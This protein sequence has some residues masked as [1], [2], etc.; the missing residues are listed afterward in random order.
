VPPLAN[1][2]QQQGEPAPA[3]EAAAAPAR[4]AGI[5]RL[6]RRALALYVQLLTRHRFV[7]CLIGLIVLLML[8]GLTLSGASWLAPGDR[9]LAPL[10]EVE[11]NETRTLIV[12]QEEGVEAYLDGMTEF[13]AERMWD[14]YADVVR[15]D[16][17]ARGRSVAE[18][19]RGLDQARRNGAAIEGRH[20]LGTYP[21]R[22]GRRYVFY[23]VARS[24]FPPAGGAEELY[25]VF[26]VDPAGKILNIT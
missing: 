19:Q 11:T 20:P 15:S 16:M 6:P 1:V 17:T 3:A 5:W 8:C 2:S 9:S 14:A 4:P 13:D 24:G 25:F 12:A 26:T 21:L 22:D 23:I 10:E 18:L 7:G